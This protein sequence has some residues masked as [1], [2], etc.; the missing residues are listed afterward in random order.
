MKLC[1]TEATKI[2]QLTAPGLP[3]HEIIGVQ[4]NGPNGLI[5]VIYD[6]GCQLIE[7][8]ELNI[9]IAEIIRR[10][11]ETM[12]AYGFDAMEAKQAATTARLIY[13]AGLRLTFWDISN[14]FRIHAMGRL[15]NVSLKTYGKPL[16]PKHIMDLLR[17]YCIDRQRYVAHYRKHMRKMKEKNKEIAPPPP[18]PEDPEY[19]RLPNSVGAQYQT[20]DRLK[21]LKERLSV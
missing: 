8:T 3:T 13:D 6:R 12:Q 2:V 10:L 20:S 7:D 17:A 21:K 15:Q 19:K 1:K 9:A 16:S 11:S 14:A 18:R 4:A 5:D